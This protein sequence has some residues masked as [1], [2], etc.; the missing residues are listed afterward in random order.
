[1][2]GI[3]D[4]SFAQDSGLWL[5]LVSCSRVR[6]WTQVSH[7]SPGGVSA[8]RLQTS[9]TPDGPWSDIELEPSGNT[10]GTQVW[11][12]SSESNDET[13]KFERYLRWNAG[14]TSGDWSIC[15]RLF[16]EY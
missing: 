8:L 16:V 4:D 7:R 13:Y 5:D 12:L 1:M 15:F 9:N 3:E 14:S 10:V 11:T 2:E 6:V